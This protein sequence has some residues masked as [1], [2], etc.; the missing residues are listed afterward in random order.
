VRASESALTGIKVSHVLRGGAAEAAGLSAGDEWW[1]STAGACAGSTI[2][3]ADFGA[4]AAGHARQRRRFADRSACRQ[5]PASRLGAAEGMAGQ[6]TPLNAR[7]LGGGAGL[8]LAVLVAHLWLVDGVAQQALKL[9]AAQTMPPRIE[10]AYVREM[11]VTA[12][13]PRP[14]PTAGAAPPRASESSCAAGVGSRQCAVARAPYCRRVC[15]G[16]R[17]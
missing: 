3:H 5:D 2:A 6:L 17:A 14:G 10:V 12:P 1:R 16:A 7:R 15:T 8:V 9:S 4:D 13:P 11:E